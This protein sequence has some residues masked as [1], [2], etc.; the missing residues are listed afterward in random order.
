MGDGIDDGILPVFFFENLVIVAQ[1]WIWR[2][3]IASIGPN[4][5][6]WMR[7]K[8]ADTRAQ[9]GPGNPLVLCIPQVPNVPIARNT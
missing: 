9:A 6:R 1:Y 4:D 3:T 8:F 7:A 2:K 5:D